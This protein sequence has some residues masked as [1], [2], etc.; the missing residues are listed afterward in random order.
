[1]PVDRG[2]QV[3]FSGY[4]ALR[5]FM[6]AVGIPR[7]D[8]RPV[9]GGAAFHDGQAWH[10]LTPTPLGLAR[11]SGMPPAD[12][13]RLA[14]LGAEVLATPDE[15]LLQMDGDAPSTEAFL[16][17]RGFSARALEGFF[18]PFWG[19]VFLD[20]SLGAD[21]GYFRFLLKM[22]LRGPAVI[23]TDGL[24]MIAEWATAAIRQA[25]GR[26]DL[27]QRVEALERDA[28]ARVGSVRIAGGGRVRARWVVLATESPSARGLLQELDPASAERLPGAA[29]SV[30][31]AAFAL[32][33]PLHSGRVILVNAAPALDTG[34]RIDL[35]CQTTNI[36]RPHVE[37]GPHILLATCVTT[38][39]GGVP[40][41]LEDAVARTVA[42]WHPG[43]PWERLATPL[44]VVEHRF[45][46]FRPLA[47][48]R[49][50]LPGPRTAV[51]NLV[52]AGDLTA[53]PSLE[54]AVSSGAAAARIVAAQL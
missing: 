53:H 17:R 49:Q 18:R 31:T 38:P 47:G 52:L 3:V 14:R 19:V 50:E 29:A 33:R 23:P 48:V 8:L 39:Q 10:R 32:A 5:R 37:A 41:D 1:R 20:R 45:A 12:R 42:R 11:F 6:R 25:G 7:A 13:L 40:D 22:L 51:P 28:D 27:G 35:M 4:P 43:F 36:T 16:R 9:T 24:G 26:V 34:P 54:G 2:F 44:G 30:A 15:A 21:P 46:Q